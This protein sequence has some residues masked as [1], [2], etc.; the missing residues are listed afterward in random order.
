MD[1]LPGQPMHDDDADVLSSLLDVHRLETVVA[2]R[3]DLAPPWRLEG[4]P[5]DSL[6]VLVQ[7]R[8]TSWI[9]SDSD[10]HDGFLDTGDVVIQPHGANQHGQPRTYLHDGSHPASVTR[11]LVP[12]GTTATPPPLRLAPPDDVSCSLVVCLMRMRGL[13]RGALW[14]TL[15]NLMYLRRNQENADGLVSRTIGSIIQ[16]SA[17]PGPAGTRLLS[18]L[19]ETLL[20]LAL[21][22]QV[23]GPS[24]GPGLRSL[25]DP[26][27]AP[28]VHLIHAS[29]GERWTVA[30]LAARCGLSRSAFAARFTAKVGETP[31]AYLVGW[32]V[33]TAGHLLATTDL[34]VTRIAEAVGYS[35]EAAFRLAFGARAGMSPRQFRKLHAR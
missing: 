11:R 1:G 24:D 25:L 30:S 13:S 16:E 33:A 17:A 28:A 8:G 9:C 15:P 27:I 31:S 6:V 4:D 34:S 26:V 14:N 2:G 7:A 35:S 18:R 12:R 19:A 3:V 29:P 20:I 21:R 23:R 10:R 22:E 32:R 5:T